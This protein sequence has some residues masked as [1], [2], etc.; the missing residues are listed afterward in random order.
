[1]K[2]FCNISNW[3]IVCFFITLVGN[4]WAI[5]ADPTPFKIQQPDGREFQARLHGDEF[6]HFI[7]TTDGY[8]V[9]KSTDGFYKYA[10]QDNN[11]N[12]QIGRASCRERV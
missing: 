6:L 5:P 2:K 1:M 4:I 11:E 12:V 7:T 8:T 10:I 9:I 3:I